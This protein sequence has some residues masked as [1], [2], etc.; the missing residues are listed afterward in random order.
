MPDPSQFV[1]GFKLVRGKKYSG[2]LL[3]D[4]SATHDAIRRYHEYS[5]YIILTFNTDN[6]KIEP[7]EFFERFVFED[8]NIFATRNMYRCS[9]SKTSYKV[10][11]NKM[12]VVLDGHSSR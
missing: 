10:V 6:A 11:G 3:E 2:Y 12:T 1:E 8:R 9:L 7:S 5:Y 4:I